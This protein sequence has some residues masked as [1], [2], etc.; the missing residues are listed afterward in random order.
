VSKFTKSLFYWEYRVNKLRKLSTEIKKQTI[1]VLIEAQREEKVILE[2]KRQRCLNTSL[3]KLI[4][5]LIDRNRS[6]K[7]LQANLGYFSKMC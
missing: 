4:K 7:K 3:K 2:R 6:I 1:W 5:F